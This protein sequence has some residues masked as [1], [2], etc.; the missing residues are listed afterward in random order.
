[1]R[2]EAIGLADGRGTRSP[3]DASR[4][5]E[6]LSDLLEYA[7]R[8]PGDTAALQ[9]ELN[10]LKGYVEL[11][12]ARFGER[13]NVRWDIGAGTDDGRALR[14]SVQPLVENSI[15]FGLEA[16]RELAI[17]IKTRAVGSRLK[18]TVIDNGPGMPK[19]RLAAVR[20]SF[21]AE[22]EGGRHVGLA[23]TAKRLALRYGKPGLLRV[24]SRPGAGTAVT[25][26]FPQTAKDRGV[27][28]TP[29]EPKHSRPP[30]VPR[31]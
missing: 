30:S 15:R 20:A 1:M 13:L 17:K 18:V 2:T 3:N 28:R 10:S 4:M 5:I 7:F 16:R 8:A 6:R 11:Q 12:T 29:P 14:L 25:L 24:L 23:N 19:E 26:I 21:A 31:A 9:D 22:Q 27:A